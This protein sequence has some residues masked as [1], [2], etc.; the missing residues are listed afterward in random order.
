MVT[1]VG[2]F[3]AVCAML[4]VLPAL[5]PLVLPAV[6]QESTMSSKSL[7]QAASQFCCA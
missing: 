7:G 5:L 6:L 2:A 3:F 1:N 4:A